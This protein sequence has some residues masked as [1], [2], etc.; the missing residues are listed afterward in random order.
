LKVYRLCK[1]VSLYVETTSSSSGSDLTD[2]VELAAIGKI[3]CLHSFSANSSIIGSGN[4]SIQI[5]TPAYLYL[6]KMD[7]GNTELLKMPLDNST[8]SVIN[9]DQA[10]IAQ[11]MLHIPGPGLF[12]NDG[13]RARIE[14]P[15]ATAAAGVT[16]SIG[17][18]N[19]VYS[20]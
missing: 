2:E 6:E 9:L 7:A 5:S 17:V 8:G 10:G 19:L 12:S 11:N 20:V 16:I 13:M 14:V 15:V 4:T 3:V 18:S 1:S